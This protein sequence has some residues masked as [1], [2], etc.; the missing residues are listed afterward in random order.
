[1]IDLQGRLA[2]GTVAVKRLKK[3]KREDYQ[4]QDNELSCMIKAKHK[5]IVRLLGYC[6]VAEKE[7]VPGQEGCFWEDANRQ[8]LLCSEYLPNGSL[9]KYIKGRS[10]H[11]HATL[12]LGLSQTKFT[13]LQF[14]FCE[15]LDICC[16][17]SVDTS[18]RFQ[19][20]TRYQIIKGLCEGL[21][22]LHKQSEPII[23]RD[24]KP[25]NILLDHNMVPKIADFGLSRIFSEGQIDSSTVNFAGT[26]YASECSVRNPTFLLASTTRLHR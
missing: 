21:D 23:H 4:F 1:M 25:G 5:N 20:S 22:Y 19:W 17:F 12:S 18:C 14:F 15:L 16:I 3:I 26:W 8:L 7:W 11:V 13:S 24:L 9:D 2:N 6:C 10:S